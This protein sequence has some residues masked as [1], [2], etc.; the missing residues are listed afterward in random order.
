MATSES[1]SPDSSLSIS[2][3]L[4][5]C[6]LESSKNSSR[7]VISV[8]YKDKLYSSASKALDAYINDFD[9][10]LTSPNA[11][12]GKITIRTSV[13]RHRT[14]K[15]VS[16]NY[17]EVTRR[18][19]LSSTRKHVSSDPD[20]L[21]LTTDDLLSFPSD[22]SLPLSQSYHYEQRFLG[23]ERKRHGPHS[24]MHTPLRTLQQ[25]A[26]LNQ[27]T[28]LN[29]HK[30]PEHNGFTDAL[31]RGS[32]KEHAPYRTER[33]N[34]PLFY[35]QTEAPYSLK[36][37]ATHD[38][39]KSYP[40]WL[41]SHKS[42]LSMSGIT[43]VPD[44]KYP[45]WLRDYGLLSDSDS[46]TKCETFKSNNHCSFPQT[47]HKHES[48]GLQS[49]TRVPNMHSHEEIK[50]RT[51][52]GQ[53]YHSDLD[54]YEHLSKHTLDVSRKK[55]QNPLKNNVSPRTEDVLGA[56]RSWEKLPFTLKSPVPVLCE[57]D[58]TLEASTKSNLVNNF[59]NDC[60]KNDDQIM[61][62]TF[63]G[64]NHHG[65]VEAL[66]HMLF[67]LQTFQQTLNQCKTTAQVD[68]FEKISKEADSHLLD[69]D[70]EMSPVNRSLQK[71]LLHLSRLKEL[72]GDSSIKP[73]LDK[74]K[75]QEV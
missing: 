48:L 41:T 64:G 6:S 59:L 52:K 43:S 16:K 47:S 57:E 7:S 29:F 3:L 54:I 13:I 37:T 45:V 26:S 75:K 19:H 51:K 4:A 10:S 67:N 72:V 1:S 25:A 2:S 74:E 69:F 46:I 42:D 55:S 58:Q 22:G 23:N 15:K 11:S 30:T 65:S 70:Q 34:K 18:N 56:E 21:S 53:T 61:T 71:A 50:K 49:N 73:E 68:D 63:S 33:E 36:E 27:R 31:Y 32:K 60:L 40:R 5:S 8:Q 44:V 24:N 12:T 20:L 38:L 66:K 28:K 14:K 39:S 62:S 35:S 17:S 9:E